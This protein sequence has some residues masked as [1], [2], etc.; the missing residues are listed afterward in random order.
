MAGIIIG[1]ILT[2]HGVRGLVKFRSYMEDIDDLAD[3]NPVMCADGRMITLTIKNSAGGEYVAAI[4]GITDR[5]IAESFRNQEIS[6][7]RDK[8]PEADDDE[9]Y[10]EDL[11]GS[12]IKNPAGESIGIVQNIVNYG[13]GDLLEIKQNSGKIFYCP[14]A[15]PYLVDI[16][17]DEKIIIIDH[18]TEFMA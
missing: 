1:K 17:I 9:F 15:E 6:V 18:Y 2:A 8:L 10:I 7:D 5:T 11:I 16:L 14:M 4:D 12:E 3:Y 13:A